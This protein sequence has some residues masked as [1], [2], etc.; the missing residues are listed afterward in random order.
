MHVDRAPAV[1]GEAGRVVHPAVDGDDEQ[2]PRDPRDR[3]RDAAEEVGAGPQPVPPVGVDADEDGLDEEGEPLQ[4]EPEAEDV[5][6]VRHP[7][8]P[9]HA[10]LERQDRAGDDADREQREHDPRPPPGQDPVQLVAGAQ[11]PVLG[12]QDEDGKRDAEAH[13]RDVHGQGERLHLARLEQVVLFSA[14]DVT[15]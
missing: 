1:Q 2:R 4:R 13:Q 3:D 14:H 5:A 11:V 10:E 7:L 6:E 8:R 12:E 9:Q 15:L